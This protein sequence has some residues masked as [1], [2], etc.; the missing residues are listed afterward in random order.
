MKLFRNIISAVFTARPNRFVV[1]CTVGGRLVR[2]YLPNPGELRELLLPGRNLYLVKQPA[3]PQR[4][5]GYMAVAVER[6]NLPILLHTHQNNFV[7]RHLIEN[8]QV[9]GLDG[10]VIVKAEHTIGNSR[11]DF[12][13]RKGGRDMVLEVKSCTLFGRRIAMF[14]DAVTERGKKHLLELASLSR[15]GMATVVLF[16]VHTPSPDYFMPDYHTDLE[17]SRALISVRD[18]ILVKA[19][20]VEWKRGLILGSRVRELSIPWEL[21]EREAQDGGSYVLIMRLTRD[22]KLKIGSLGTVRFRKGFY[23]YTG[24]AKKFLTQRI[25]RHRSRRKKLFWHIDYL[26]EHADFCT[27]LPVRASVDLECD[28]A[29]ALRGISPWTI[30]GFGSSDCSCDSHLFGMVDDPLHDPA[31]IEMLQYFRIDRLEK[32]L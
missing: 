23:L 15:Q 10:A 13:L 9:P 19:V 20:S 26:R 30:P 27:A 29:D 5:I 16:L 11:F 6:D 24:S 17:F 4:K 21:I 7:S 2:A 31:F 32:E 18:D 28:L 8:N 1:E 12:L 14:P 3:V 25:A 22:R